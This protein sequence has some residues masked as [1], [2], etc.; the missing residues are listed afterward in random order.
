M[1]AHQPS[2]SMDAAIRSYLASARSVNGLAENTLAAQKRDLNLLKDWMEQQHLSVQDLDPEDLQRF[3]AALQPA[4]APSSIARLTSTLHSFGAF[5][6]LRYDLNDAAIALHAPARTDELPQWL[7]ESQVLS[8]LQE[9]DRDDRHLIDAVVAVTL[10]CAGLRVSELCSLKDRDVRLDAGQIRVQGKGGKERLVPIAPA[11]RPW[12]ES[13]QRKI[14]S[15]KPA[16][17][18]FFVNR[19]GRALNRQYVFRLIRRLSLE[20]QLPPTTSPHTLRHSFATSLLKDGADLRVIQ[21]LLG[22]SDISTTQIY[23]HLDSARILSAYDQAM[24]NPAEG[25]DGIE[26]NC[27][28]D[29]KE[30]TS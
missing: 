25:D 23:T 29:S 21:E 2:L 15:Q 22:H 3:V 20:H 4:Y 12:L 24:K 8:M 9:A 30:E 27:Y 7:D 14:R 1:S 19:L 11:L 18:A 13:Y 6:S 26:M 10:Y 17:G 16:G 5:L 28:K